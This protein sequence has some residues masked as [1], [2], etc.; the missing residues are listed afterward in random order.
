MRKTRAL[1]TT[2]IQPKSWSNPYTRIRYKQRI[3]TIRVFF[4]REL[5]LRYR[6]T[7]L[8]PLWHFFQPIISSLT[9]FAIF[10]KIVGINTGQI[11]APLFYLTGVILWQF[12]SQ[13]VESTSGSL[14]GNRHLYTKIFIWK[15]AIPIAGISYRLFN[16]AMQLISVGCMVL[17]LK[18][19]GHPL[20]DFNWGRYLLSL[21]PV[22]AFTAAFALGI[23]LLISTIS[24]YFRDILQ[25]QGFLLQLGMYVTPVLYPSQTI[26]EKYRSLIFLNPLATILE[27]QRNFV[28]KLGPIPWHALTNC[29]AGII[30][31]LIISNFIY[32]YTSQDFIDRV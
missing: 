23:G 29:S 25:V 3:R 4:K 10:Q 28:F 20:Y 13:S 6:N 27:S 14:Q 18:G 16:F 30:T 21:L 32:R 31:L 8:G 7:W 22:V 26:P 9:F 15:L 5:L 2:I 1:A 19:L 17:I 24:V 11:P 12:F